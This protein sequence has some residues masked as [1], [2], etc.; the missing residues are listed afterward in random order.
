VAHEILDIE[1]VHP[2]KGYSH[3][4]R[5]GNLFVEIALYPARLISQI[6]WMEV[7]A[8]ARDEDTFP[9]RDGTFTSTG[10]IEYGFEPR[11]YW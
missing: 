3:A 1:T 6:T 5:A 10:C 11:R 2:T 7:L 9:F 4:A 8:G